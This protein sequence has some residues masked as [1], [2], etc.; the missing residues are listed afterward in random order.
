MQLSAWLIRCFFIV[1]NTEFRHITISGPPAGY[2]THK[3]VAGI[4]SCDI[5]IFS[6]VVEKI[7]I[8]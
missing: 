2:L 8:P 4:L 5:V 1:Y 3:A 7:T 6:A